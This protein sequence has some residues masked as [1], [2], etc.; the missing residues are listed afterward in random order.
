V[1]L[2]K[3]M[4]WGRLVKSSLNSHSQTSSIWL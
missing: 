2:S 1:F 3:E 4:D